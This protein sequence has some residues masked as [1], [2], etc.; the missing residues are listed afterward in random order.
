MRRLCAVVMLAATVG[1]T[2]AAPPP[3]P[4]PAVR[5]VIFVTIDTL[6][7]DHTSVGGYPAPTTPFLER[8]AARGV[9]FDRAYS[10]SATTA[11]SHASMF[12]GLLPIQ[13]RVQTNGLRLADELATLPEVLS[14]AGWDT[15]GVVAVPMIFRS[16]ALT[17]GFSEFTSRTVVR[18]PET[19]RPADATAAAAA[20]WLRARDGDT[21]PFFL[22]MHVYDP[23]NPLRPPDEAIEAV[24]PTNERSERQRRRALREQNIQRRPTSRTNRQV[25]QYD[26]EIRFVDDQLE[27]LHAVTE[28]LGLNDD[29]L[30]VVTADHGQGLGTHRWYGHHVQLYNEQLHVPMILRFPGDWNAGHRVSEH[31]ATHVDLAPTLLEIL[32]L[33]PLA[34]AL[35][36]PGRSLVPLFGTTPEW[37]RTAVFA[38]RRIAIEDGRGLGNAGPKLEEGT[39]Q[40]LQ[41]LTRKYML[42]SHG[43][44]EYYHLDAD[45]YE[46]INL[47]DEADIE[48]R[49]LRDQLMALVAALDTGGTAATVSEADLEE[50][51][52]LGYVQ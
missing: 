14:E 40:A 22:W 23:H 21:D 9:T 10:H 45:P 43:P 12:T 8:L 3:P 1:C 25:L 7:A 51:R 49:L 4:W 30:W 48:A 35:P 18:R 44:D 47:I 16:S 6:R 20:D 46:Q 11:P 2:A 26:A 19:Y 29:T 39:R 32:G 38:E 31:A 15:A 28:E 34:Q 13:H 17:R 33:G 37:D 5:N 36:L 41:T 42:V 52:A 27:R 24:S 50:L